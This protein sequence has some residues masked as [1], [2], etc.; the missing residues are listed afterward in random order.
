MSGGEMARSE[1]GRWKRFWRS[2][3]TSVPML[4]VKRAIRQRTGREPRS[5]VQVRCA[6][7]EHGEWWICPDAVRAG[8]VVY[9]FGIG[10]DLRFERA[11]ATEYGTR[12]FAFD[13]T[14]WTA[15]WVAGERLP[16]NLRYIPMCVAGYDGEADLHEPE[17]RDGSHSM[18]AQG[19]QTGRTVP[20]PV[21]RLPSL[22]REL[23]HDRID[24]LKLDVEGAEYDAVR[25]LLAMDIT[26]RQVLVEFH[27]RFGRIGPEPTR[28]ALR[29]LDDAGYR[30][31]HIS[32]HGR[33]FSFIHEDA[34]P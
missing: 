12:V 6:R 23:G 21:R 5:R 9:A 2:L 30:V 11:M 34:L 4:R 19:G 25:D 7:Q 15:E 10:R 24:L 26:V 16:E 13:P 18:V 27:H 33:E 1:Y 8:D 28:E 31:F 29:L 17:R 3:E 32:P 14:P 20:V 22:M